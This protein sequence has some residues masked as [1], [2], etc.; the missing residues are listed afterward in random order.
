MPV[1]GTTISPIPTG[2]C[3]AAPDEPDHQPHGQHSCTGDPPFVASREARASHPAEDSGGDQQRQPAAQHVQDHEPTH[4]EVG[5]TA[6]TLRCGGHARLPF[7]TAPPCSCQGA[8]KFQLFWWNHC[9]P[10]PLGQGQ[11]SRGASRSTGYR[12]GWGG[13]AGESGRETGNRSGPAFLLIRSHGRS[14]CLAGHAGVVP[15]PQ[16][17]ALI[18]VLTK[19]GQADTPG[20]RDQRG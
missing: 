7:S 13:H 2:V 18:A 14:E 10:S 1:G 8:A 6:L 12:L 20:P 11:K 17:L 16:R 9:P 5:E 15:L 19:F 3:T 4:S